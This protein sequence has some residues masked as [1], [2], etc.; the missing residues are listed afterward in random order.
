MNSLCFP[1]AQT[2]ST[3]RPQMET[4]RKGGR[5]RQRG[6]VGD[7]TIKSFFSPDCV[8]LSTE[9]TISTRKAIVLND[10]H[11]PLDFV[12]RSFFFFFKSDLFSTCF[13][14][15]L[16]CMKL[17]VWNYCVASNSI[18]RSSTPFDGTTAWALNTALCSP[19]GPA[20]PRSTST[21]C[22]RF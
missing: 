9:K 17:P 7:R 22:A 2:V 4:G 19:L 14:G 1:T 12:F 13:P 21:T 18:T 6:R 16:R 5:H 20:T 11:I 10:S 8:T 3:H 15:V